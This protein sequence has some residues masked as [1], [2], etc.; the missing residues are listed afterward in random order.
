MVQLHIPQQQTYS[1]GQ[2][3]LR[4]LFGWIYLGIP[5]S[6]CIY[7][8]NFMNSILAW[9][10]WWILIF[11]GSFPQGLQK[12]ML[13]M[14]VSVARWYAFQL[15]MRDGFPELAPSQDGNEISLPFIEL[16]YSRGRALLLV[17]FMPIYTIFY[18]IIAILLW[19]VLGFVSWV[20][21]WIVLFQGEMN[22]ELYKIMTNCVSF[23]F[24]IRLFLYGLY[25]KFPGMEA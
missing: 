10:S 4:A 21:F 14:E 3:L 19:I 7:V 22:D 15:G 16:K 8:Y 11:T 25:Q 17:L 18:G 1:R 12:I 2:A 20:Q 6:L 9:I 5:A 13:N 23:A 24:T